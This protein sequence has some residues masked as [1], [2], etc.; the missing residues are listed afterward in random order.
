MEQ[1]QVKTVTIDGVEY[2]IEKLSAESKLALSHVADLDQKLAGIDYQRQQLQV[3]R[4]AF[5]TILKAELAKQDQAEDE[6][7]ATA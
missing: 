5:F 2:E 6:T 3:G 1:N 4:D 7:K